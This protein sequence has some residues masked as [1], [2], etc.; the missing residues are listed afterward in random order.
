[1]EIINELVSKIKL[2][3][4]G[5]RSSQRKVMQLPLS[6]VGAAVIAILVQFYD[7]LHIGPLGGLPFRPHKQ[8]VAPLKEVLRSW[9]KDAANQLRHAKEEF[10]D[11]VF[12]PES[13]AFDGHGRG[14]Y[15]GL[16]DGRVVRWMGEHIG[17]ETFAVPSD[18]WNRVDC[19]QG[20]DKKLREKNEHICGRPLGL[21]F[22]KKTGNLYIA[23]SYY[24]LLVVGPEGGIAKPVVNEVG[25]QPILF[26]ND[27]DIHET[28]YI[29]FTDTST[30]WNR[31]LHQMAII[32]GEN[33]GRLLRYDP[34]TNSTTVVL[35]G[36]HFA[37]GVQLSADQSFLLVVETAPCRILRYWLE[38]SA[39]GS[40]EV[41]AELPGYPDNVRMNSE[42]Q[43]WVAIDCCRTYSQE[44]LSRNPFLKNVLFRLPLPYS[45]IIRAISQKMYSVI[46]LF[47][48][49]GKLLKTMEDKEGEAVKLVSEVQEKDGKIWL[50]TVFHNHI[51]TLPYK[52]D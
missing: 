7:P 5:K 6:F 1:M 47:D 34:S 21:R 50:A 45:L 11:Q 39:A 4:C 51:S 26:A 22:E 2:L 15:T 48:A 37:N 35:Q 17:W 3:V 18:K 32:E 36:L 12:G 52:L 10:K 19:N 44:F 30:R 33:T 24:G 13:L 27:L 8:R 43:F 14:P 28:G 40:V 41:F 31:R 42:G 46:A 49:T 23:D 29:F 20:K 9:P 16:A 38:G 25:G